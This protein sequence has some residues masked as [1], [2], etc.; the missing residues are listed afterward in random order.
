MI[1]K[2]LC[3]CL[4]GRRCRTLA[5][6][7]K[8][9]FTLVELLVVIAIIG[10]LVALLLPAVQAAREASR[11]ASCTN[12]MKN[13]GV[14]MH[15]YLTAR[16]EFPPGRNGC[17]SSTSPCNCPAAPGTYDG[18]SG[19]VMMLPYVEDPKMYEMAHFE[20]GGVFNWSLNPPWENDSDR[21][22]MARLR[23]AILV[24]P[25]NQARPTCEG[26]VNNNGNP[27]PGFAL[28]ETQSGTSS[29]ALCHGTYGPKVFVGTP[30]S[31]R[32]PTT[33]CGNTGM[34]VEANRRRPKQITDG[35]S[36]TFAGGEIKGGDTNDGYSLWAYGSCHESTLRT[37]ANALNTPPGQPNPSGVRVEVWGNLNGAF[38]SDH[39]GSG[40]NF[41]YGDGH[42]E[43]I[44]E[45]IDYNLYQDLATIASQ[46]PKG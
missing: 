7:C 27:K 37:T 1:D 13:I 22:A 6:R 14:A 4:A 29:Y 3:G 34:F 9:G 19:Y 23:P 21:N 40:A 42:V 36:K 17:E 32:G 18:S 30:S 2:R 45:D 10:V 39:A 20:K 31:D 43:F 12:N 26:C 8:G 5:C 16:K 25:S 41:L 46:P 28:I 35:L 11:R 44:S 38:G 33:L 24:C 15:N